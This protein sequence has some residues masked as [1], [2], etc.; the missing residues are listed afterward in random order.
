MAYSYPPTRGARE[1]TRD[2]GIDSPR[3]LDVLG[4][5][6]DDSEVPYVM[7]LPP[8]VP[9][10]ARLDLNARRSG[11]KWMRSES[12]G[13]QIRSRKFPKSEKIVDF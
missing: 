7:Y 8:G 4:I 9:V 1:G 10:A 3:S 5:T 12:P 6:C 2:L 11:A 13:E